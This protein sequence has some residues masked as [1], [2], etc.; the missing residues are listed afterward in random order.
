M[1]PINK[2]EKEFRSQLSFNSSG[3]SLKLKSIV[4][5]CSETSVRMMSL[6]RVCSRQQFSDVYLIMERS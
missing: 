6:R 1:M 3:L 5:D 4:L 2:Y